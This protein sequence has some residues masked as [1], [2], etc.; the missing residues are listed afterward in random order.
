[1]LRARMRQWDVEV[2]YAA[3]VP[4]DPEAVASA[5][6]QR[7]GGADLVVTTGGVSV[8]KK[9]IMHDVLNILGAERLFWRVGIK[10]G[11]PT[12]AGLYQ[13]RLMVCLSGNPYGAIANLELLVRP[14]VAKMSRHQS[15]GLKRKTAELKNSYGKNSPVTRYVRAVYENGQVKIAAGS[16][17]SG[18]LS[19]MRGCNCMVEVPA[20]SRGLEK[21]E[22]VW[23]V[24]L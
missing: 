8:G 7:I 3:L 23:V 1:M 19:T 6:R 9:D 11:M 5:I 2:V 18:I 14:I 21:G 16:N 17:D 24:M 4:D 12:L 13:D 20:G 10:P 22:R 15:L